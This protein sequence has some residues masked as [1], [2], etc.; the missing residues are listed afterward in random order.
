ML[1][2]G[3]ASVAVQANSRNSPAFVTFG[4]FKVTL[5][6]GTE[7][8]KNSNLITLKRSPLNSQKLPI[9]GND[10]TLNCDLD[11]SPEGDAVHGPFARR[12]L[13]FELLILAKLHVLHAKVKDPLRRVRL[14]FTARTS[15]LNFLI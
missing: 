9:L 15:S 1:D 10:P 12:H 2:L 14:Q 3:L 7:I 5:V 4:S 6:G 8:N 13:A 11:G